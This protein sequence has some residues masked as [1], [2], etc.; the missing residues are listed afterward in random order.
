[1]TLR[2]AIEEVNGRPL[3]TDKK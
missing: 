3:Q 1:M 2:S